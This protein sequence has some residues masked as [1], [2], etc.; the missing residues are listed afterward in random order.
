GVLRA[1]EQG[2]GGTVGGA[3]VIHPASGDILALVD[4]SAFNP[5][6]YVGVEDLS[7]FNRAV[8]GRY[9]PGSAMKVVTAAAALDSG[10]FTP[11][12][13]L[14]GP[15]EYKG[16]RNFES[17]A[18]GSVDFATAM[19][20]SVNTAFAQI[21]ER[22][23]GKR[24]TKYAEAFGFNREIDIPLAHAVSQYPEPEDAGDLMWSAIGQAQVL[25]TPLQMATVAATVANGGK[26][27]EPRIDRDERRRGERVVSR[28]VARQLTS[29]ME[30]VVNGGTGVGAR[31]SGTQVAGKTGTAEV[32]VGGERR[33]HAW[34][35]AFAPSGA[36]KVAVAVVAEY[37]GVGGQVAAPLARQI[38][39]NVLPV[40]P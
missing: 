30:N 33:N 15:A 28:R 35:I 27:M 40:A 1:A 4:S 39:A 22:L 29:M 25:A 8:V 3:A 14:Q 26:R 32:D 20:F 31:L 17:G 19:K 10:R 36:P 5:G 16:V 37:G 38:L 2:F 34:F 23:G 9:P 7:P 11:E 21:A 24:M 13:R 6:F 18:F 12:S